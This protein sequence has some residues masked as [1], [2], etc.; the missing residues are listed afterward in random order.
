MMPLYDAFI[1]SSLSPSLPLLSLSLSLPLSPPS[2][3][4]LSLSPSL[5]PLPPPSLSVFALL[6][7]GSHL[8]VAV[9]RMSDG[10]LLLSL[11]GTSHTIYMREEVDKY[12]VVIGGKTC[13]FEKENDP[14]K[15]RYCSRK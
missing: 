8:E 11:D 12:R 6:M 1:I 9:H 2:L 14:T 3:P 7:N 15:L 13:V 4:L 10:S 5:S